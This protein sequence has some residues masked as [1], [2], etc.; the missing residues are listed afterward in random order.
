M[1]GGG[2]LAGEA[3][4]GCVGFPIPINGFAAAACKKRTND[5]QFYIYVHVTIT[6]EFKLHCQTIMVA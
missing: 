6:V 2:G 1:D 3:E 4:M 5:D